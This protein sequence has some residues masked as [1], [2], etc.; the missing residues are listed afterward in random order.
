MKDSHENRRERDLVLSQ[1]EFAYILDETKGHVIVYVGPHKTSLANTDQPV[2]FDTPSRRFRSCSL[3]ISITSFPF[4]EEGWYLELENPG[5]ADDSAHPRPGP[6]SLPKLTFGRK[7]SIA[8]PTTFPLWPGQVAR[9]IQGHQLRSNQYL[10]V[11][12][13]NEDAARE[14][15]SRAVI[16]TR[17]AT[18][19][20][21]EDLTTG[22]ELVIRGTEV[23]FVIPPTGVEVVQDSHGRYIR[24]AV[25]LERLEYCILLDEDGH[26][27]YLQGPQVVFPHP[28]EVFVE[29]AGQRKF[30]AVELHE[31]SGIYLKVIAPYS[32]ENGLNHEVGDELFLTGKEQKIYFPRPE[33][34]VIRYG[35]HQIHHAIAIPSGEARYVLNRDT[36]SIALVKGPRMFLP[37]PRHEVVVRR[38]LESEQVA[39]WFPDSNEAMAHNVALRDKPETQRKQAAAQTPE[40]T[41]EVIKG[42]GF[43]RG[44]SF[45]P[46]RT[47]I[48]DDRY[49]GAVN[50]DVWTGYAVQVVDREGH[51]EVVVGPASRLLEYTETL[52]RLTLSRGL[53]KSDQE[54]L[55]TVYL[56]VLNNQVTDR[57]VAETSDLVKVDLTLSYRVSFTGDP[58]HWF[59]VEN[60]VKFL[61]E[62]QRSHL[63]AEIKKASVEDLFQDA[64]RRVRDAVLGHPDAQ[65]ERP[66][67]TFEENGMRIYD[68]DVLDF[69]VG[70]EKVARL[71]MSAQQEAVEQTV[72]LTQHRRE[73]AI[74]QERE[75]LTRSIES[76][77]A[78]TAALKADLA[79]AEIE[80][81]AALGLARLE[82]EAQ[83]T[84][85]GVDLELERQ[86][87][88]NAL[89]AS[90]RER[91]RLMSEQEIDLAQKRQQQELERLR[92]EVAGMVEKAHAI[93]P[94]LVAALQAFG[95]RHLAE[96]MASS[97]APLAI[98][99][100]ESV[101]DALGR[102]LK[103]TPLENVVRALPNGSNAA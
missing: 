56:R 99:G 101:A 2:Y 39:L 31:L 15:W 27:R 86:E 98:L 93:S 10:L 62:N 85:R 30:R 17:D 29:D 77:K 68:V 7:V 4:A 103:N 1:N 43:E 52:E 59:S 94:D 72:A 20:S 49:E 90:A 87:T 14:N 66:G 28:T 100:G 21:E 80:R 51:R 40:P 47:L 50:I 102:L 88:L 48:L 36:G 89:S 69:S 23:A 35:S 18:Q 41:S 44:R 63:R 25:T 92:A 55:E 70:E 34:A 54:P 96:K 67:K 38:V 33:H 19:L 5:P 82:S 75:K 3:E 46:P 22:K 76:V 8:G 45:S 74:T 71:L 9:V 53:P 84:R 24:E 12:V 42:E 83:A 11:R 13:Y 26:K 97:M 95:D 60:Y 6:N 32:D 81:S 73:L 91:T 61:T 64:V 37:D 78:E 16:K 79:R 58:Q 65:G 57:L